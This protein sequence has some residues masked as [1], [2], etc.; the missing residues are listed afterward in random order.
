MTCVYIEECS[1]IDVRYV[2][3]LLI[4]VNIY[5]YIFFLAIGMISM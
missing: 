3:I 4:Y 1:F 2:D 5:I